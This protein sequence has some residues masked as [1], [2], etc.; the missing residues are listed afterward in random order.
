MS[1]YTARFTNFDAEIDFKP[2]TPENSKV[3]A[4]IYPTSIKT[5]YPHPEK[6]DFDKKL[7]EKEE[8]FNA[9]E[10]PDIT[11]TSTNIEM[12]GEN[13]ATMTGDLTFLGVTKP[14]SLNVTFNGA[15]KK[16]PFSKKPTLGFSASGSLKRSEWGMATYIPNIGDEVMLLIEAEFAKH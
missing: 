1:N 15:M 16:Q 3:T 8:W 9:N 7:V 13:T 10:F 2:Q 6:K 5:D 14:V 4:T 12:T 11:F